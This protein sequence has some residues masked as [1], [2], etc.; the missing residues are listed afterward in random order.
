MTHLI[1]SIFAPKLWPK[2]VLMIF[3][4]LSVIFA[5]I[6]IHESLVAVGSSNSVQHIDKIMHAL[7]YAILTGAMRLGWPVIWGGFIV[8]AA[9]TLGVGLEFA[10]ALTAQ[11]RTGSLADAIANVFGACLALAILIP[12]RR[13]G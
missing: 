10:Q 13:R 3:K 11:G 12:F 8:I 6:I 4:G 9:G 2:P 5:L 7:A 1:A